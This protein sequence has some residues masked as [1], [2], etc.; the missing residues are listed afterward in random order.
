MI[1]EKAI[2]VIRSW[3]FLSGDEIEALETLI[4]EY[5][6][7]NGNGQELNEA[8]LGIPKGAD[9]TDKKYCIHKE[10][11]K[12]HANDDNGEAS[13]ANGHLTGKILVEYGA[14][15]KV[16]DGKRHCE[17]DWKEFQRLAHYFYE[18]GRGNSEKPN[19]HAEWSEK[20]ERMMNR[21]I[22]RL[23]F[24]QYNTRT[25]GT[26]L[27]IS[28]VN[29]IEW[30]KSLPKM[31]KK[32]NDDVKKLC[33]NE[34]SEEDEEMIGNIIGSLRGYTYYI[35]QNGNYNNHEAYIQ[36]QIEFLNSLRPSWK[37]SENK[38]SKNSK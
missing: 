2:K 32:K 26:S 3:N 17:M 6:D 33:S 21:L 24:I 20:D 23:N 15:A 25:D 37:P 28:F 9:P 16:R 29:E 36:K 10:Y 31:L 11:L 30:L 38:D 27:N 12:N 8:V 4:P 1:R 7:N 34:W 18:L 14:H 19:N 35:R 5:R 22:D 13:D